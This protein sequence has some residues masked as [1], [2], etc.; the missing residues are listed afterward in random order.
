MEADEPIENDRSLR[1]SDAVRMAL[2][3]AGVDT[4][5]P[6]IIHAVNTVYDAYSRHEERVME[7]VA[8]RVLTE[9]RAR[10]ALAAEKHKRDARKEKLLFLVSVAVGGLSSAIASLLYGYEKFID[11]LQSLFGPR[12]VHGMLNVFPSAYA[13]TTTSITPAG[14]AA[15]LGPIVVYGIYVLFAVGYVA[16]LISLLFGQDSR[17]DIALDIFKT[18]SAFFIGAISGRFV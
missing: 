8:V 14:P 4:S 1:V 3:H 9:D 7:R 10:A 15:Q 12:F 17:K 13:E 6:R 2:E 16:S 18:I 11:A 5:D